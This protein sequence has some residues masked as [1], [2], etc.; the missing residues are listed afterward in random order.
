[1]LRQLMTRARKGLL[2]AVS[3]DRVVWGRM[4]A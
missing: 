3:A 4:A 2:D 1:V